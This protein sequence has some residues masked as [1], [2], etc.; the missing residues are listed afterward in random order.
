MRNSNHTGGLREWVQR[1]CAFKVIQMYNNKLQTTSGLKVPELLHSTL[2]GGLFP[3][4][5]VYSF[6]NAII[7]RQCTS[8]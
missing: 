4:K 8:Q 1:V 5:G 6:G 2:H 7:S 3:A